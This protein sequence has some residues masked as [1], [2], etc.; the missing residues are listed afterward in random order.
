MGFPE[1]DGSKQQSDSRPLTGSSVPPLEGEVV[2]DE[3]PLE[4]ELT[5]ASPRRKKKKDD[6][7]QGDMD[8]L[9]KDSSAGLLLVERGK[10]AIEAVNDPEVRELI[11]VAAREGAEK[12]A[13]VATVNTLNANLDGIARVARSWRSMTNGLAQA[14]PEEMKLYVQKI[15]DT[16]REELEAAGKLPEEAKAIAERSI[17]LHSPLVVAAFLESIRQPIVDTAAWP[18]LVSDAVEQKVTE[19][20]YAKE[21]T[22]ATLRAQRDQTLAIAKMGADE[23]IATEAARVSD[24][25]ETGSE[26]EARLKRAKGKVA[27]S[28]I[29]GRVEAWS[30]APVAIPHGL[31]S[32]LRYFQERH[33][34]AAGTTAIGLVTGIGV[35]IFRPEVALALGSKLGWVTQVAGPE[36][37]TIIFF[38][39]S[40]LFVGGLVVE[41]I[42]K[43]IHESVADLKEWNKERV[44]RAKAEREAKEQ[45]AEQRARAER[46]AKQQRSNPRD[47]VG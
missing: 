39:V 1:R 18:W 40:G 16:E 29:V 30:A 44:Q 25:I 24:V 47:R 11:K 37:A 2:D 20:R 3:A 26:A 43:K 10:A 12:L 6:G 46:E 13:L 32:G 41:G 31:V 8:K 19:S 14:F 7:L 27:G 4:Q 34:A 36:G 23:A 42:A 15:Q 38:F 17:T 28:A 5:P 33:A 21:K 35:V 22:L 45:R 9:M